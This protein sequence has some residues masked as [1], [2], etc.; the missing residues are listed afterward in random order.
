MRYANRLSFALL[1]VPALALGACSKEPSGQKPTTQVAVSAG[2]ML[3]PEPGLYTNTVTV[4]KFEMPGMPPSMAQQMKQT[5]T[6]QSGTDRTSCLTKEDAA[7]GYEDMV[8]KMGQG[9]DGMKCTFSRY[10][11]SGNNLDA[12]L[13]CAGPEGTSATMQMHG[14][15]ESGKSN[16]TMEMTTRA[17]HMP[18]GQMTMAMQVESVRTGECGA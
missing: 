13:N 14:T 8:Q 16:I 11:V 15:V 17:K 9:R 6:S 18:G 7:K 10:N 1:A 12:E 4:T 5:F 3:K 2:G